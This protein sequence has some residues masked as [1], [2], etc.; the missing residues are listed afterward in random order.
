MRRLPSL[1]LALLLAGAAGLQ[2]QATADQA[3]LMFTLGFG[4]T[5]GG[6]TLWRVGRQPFI[7][8][9]GAVDTLA[10]SRAFGR[11]L[12]VTFSGTYFPNDNLGFNVEAQLLGLVTQDDC[13][14]VSTVGDTLGPDLCRSI[15][16]GSRN[17]SAVGLSG[18][19]VYRAFSKQPLHP[20]FRASAGFVVSQQSY[21][22]TAGRVGIDSDSTAAADLTLYADDSPGSIQPYY[23]LGGGVV[24]VV[25][26]GYQFRAEV[27]DN[28]V[29]V[30]SVAGA[31]LRQGVKPPSTQVGKHFLTFLI[32]FDI[33]L[34]R[35]RGRRY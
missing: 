29:R 34:E 14:L 16:G 9:P 25:G 32:G 13:R 23:S 10:V 19:L 35:K 3:R 26:R 15:N 24:A 18:G 33:V 27:R 17:A 20:F 31:T 22:R 30:P 11:S 4:Q 5:S 12:A 28:W 2:A 21:L 8:G 7:V 1:C 6:G